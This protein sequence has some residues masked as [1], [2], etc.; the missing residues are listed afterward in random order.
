MAF[1]Q[2]DGIAGLERYHRAEELREQRW[3]CNLPY[4]G[5]CESGKVYLSLCG[6]GRMRGRWIGI[7]IVACSRDP[8]A[9][10]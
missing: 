1:R 10:D 8:W 5:R 2:K 3:A 7:A 9:L 6:S 4:G